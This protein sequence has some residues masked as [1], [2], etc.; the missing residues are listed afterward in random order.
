VIRHLSAA[1]LLALAVPQLAAARPATVHV[2]EAEARAEPRR[3]APVI[4]R[5]S[6]GTQVSVDEE[7]RDGWRRVRLQDG[8]V[9]WVEDAALTLGGPAPGPTVT[10]SPRA[11]VG[12]ALAPAPA[13]AP[14]LRARVYVKDIDHLAELMQKDE[15]IGAQARSLATRRTA[16]W[17]ALGVGVAAGAGL[18]AFGMNRYSSALDRSH[19]R[20]DVA[21]DTSAGTRLV[22]AGGATFTASILAYLLLTPRRN[23][24]LDVVNAWNGAHPG[25][26][27]ELE[28]ATNTAR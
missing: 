2:F 17:V 12:A 18:F 20:P 14:D 11:A 22:A 10:G 3:D 21:P 23:E 4:Q 8:A 6:E 27:F 26:P 16:A 15:V 1:A 13:G 24:I 5:F 25:E 28:H 19:D 9:G 7:S